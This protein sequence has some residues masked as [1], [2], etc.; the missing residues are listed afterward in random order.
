MK[1]HQKP[2]AYSEEERNK[3]ILER[4]KAK[5]LAITLQLRLRDAQD[6]FEK[7]LRYKLEAAE[8]EH[9]AELARERELA[10]RIIERLKHGT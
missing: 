1:R 7:I 8:K 5:N 4:D 2:P 3:L 9:K 6:D 10:A